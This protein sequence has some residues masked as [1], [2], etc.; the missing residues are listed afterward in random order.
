MIP[1]DTRTGMLEADRRRS[2]LRRRWR[3]QRRSLPDPPAVTPAVTPAAES[4]A[5]G[6][7]AD[8]A[9]GSRDTEAVHPAGDAHGFGAR[10]A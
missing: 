3:S 9:A 1:M 6:A 10:A 2:R 7:P 4:P 8:G 5:D